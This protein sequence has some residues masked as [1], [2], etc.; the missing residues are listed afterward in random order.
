MRLSLP[1]TRVG[2]LCC[3]VFT[4]APAAVVDAAS[5][6]PATVAPTSIEKV[7]DGVETPISK[8]LTPPVPVRLRPVFKSGVEKHPFVLTLDEDLHKTF[9]LNDLQRQSASWSA[10]C[11][12][13]GLGQVFSAIQK[14]KTE[15]ETRKAREQVL[16]EL[17]ELEAAR[18]AAII[19]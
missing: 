9:D 11:C 16:R 14:S 3:A 18:A 7:K 1:A 12:G 4:V 6:D 2:L 8:P 13:I 17:A 19:K 10:R 5:Q 15:S